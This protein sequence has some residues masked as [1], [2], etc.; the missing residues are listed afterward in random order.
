MKSVIENQQPVKFAAYCFPN[1][2]L[3]GYGNSQQRQLWGDVGQRGRLLRYSTWA[4]LMVF[5]FSRH[6]DIHWHP[7]PN[8]CL[9][10]CAKC[11]VSSVQKAVLWGCWQ[12]VPFS[13]YFRVSL[14]QLPTT[15][16]AAI[17]RKTARRLM[18]KLHT[19][20]LERGY[21]SQ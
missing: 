14:C 21:L 20:K 1:R 17:S 6:P 16:A 11:R 4:R 2:K 7:G 9:F 5:H 12:Q 10:L 3:K 13:P 18:R 8:N 19:C 15:L